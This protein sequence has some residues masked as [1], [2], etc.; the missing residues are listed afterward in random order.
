MKRAGQRHRTNVQVLC[1][2][3][4]LTI[5]PAIYPARFRGVLNWGPQ[6]FRPD[7]DEACEVPR[8]QWA[9]RTGDV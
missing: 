4:G 6:M 3:W 9:E 7:K 8:G 1:D 2:L 5:F